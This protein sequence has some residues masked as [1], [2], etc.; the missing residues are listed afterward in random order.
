MYTKGKWTTGK[1]GLEDMLI[2]PSG[3]S[4]QAPGDSL[5]ECAANAERICHCVN[6]FDDLL[7]A[8]KYAKTALKRQEV[9]VINAEA[10]TILEEVIAKAEVRKKYKKCQFFS[11]QTKV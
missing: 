6:N 10:I 1:D 2:L 11:G 9:G 7:E 3:E 8:C 5:E 4:A